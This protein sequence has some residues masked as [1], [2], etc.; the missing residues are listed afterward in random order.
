MNKNLRSKIKS[1]LK[2]TGFSLLTFIL[3]LSVVVFIFPMFKHREETRTGVHTVSVYIMK[4][5]VH[6]DF[7]VP[8]HHKIQDWD[9]LFPYENNKVV[10]TSFHWLAI[11]V[12]DKQFFLST[13]T[14][15]DLTFSTAIRS[16]FG[17]NGAAMHAS[18]HYEIPKDRPVVKLRVTEKQYSR[19]CGYIRSAINYKHGKPELLYSNVKGTTFSYDRYYG[20]RRSYSFVNNCNAWV[21]SG[22]K[23]AGQ[24]ACFWT[25]LAEG[26]FRH[27]GK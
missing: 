8:V 22:L 21:N 6:T 16:V 9:K 1:A 3:V 24:R 14:F 27:Y 17:M 12:G 25:V 7:I 18:Y 19:L 10:D 4:S 26:I 2:I 15:A 23:V 13:P 11:G 5:G 20:S